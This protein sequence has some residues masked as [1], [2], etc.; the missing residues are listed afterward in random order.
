MLN[1][2]KKFKD[3][4]TEPEIFN[5][6]RKL[7]FSLKEMKIFSEK[8]AF[9]VLKRGVEDDLTGFWSLCK[10]MFYDKF[11]KDTK[12]GKVSM[13]DY[14]KAVETIEQYKIEQLEFDRI[15]H[16]KPTNTS[17]PEERWGV[18]RTHCC[19]KHGCKY[20]DDDCPVEIGLIAQ[21]YLCESC[22]QDD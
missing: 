19:F 18:H 3:Y 14:R 12:Y 7:L 9:R 16:K 21:D 22:T 11:K 13:E 10:E 17:I 8:F 20:G 1:V 6:D 2:H 15:D 4:P 5:E